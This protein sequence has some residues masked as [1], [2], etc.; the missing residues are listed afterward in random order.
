[1]KINVKALEAVR[2]IDVDSVDWE[3]NGRKGTT[4]KA[5]CHQKA[6]GKVSVEEVRISEDLYKDLKPMQYYLFGGSLDLKGNRFVADTAELV[7]APNK[8]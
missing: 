3:M 1:M 6:N 7:N 5:F 8:Q 4:Y 2:V